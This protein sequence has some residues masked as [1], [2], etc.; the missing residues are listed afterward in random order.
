MTHYRVRKS[1]RK[2]M[3]IHILSDGQVE[4]RAPLRTPQA[5][6]DRF[7]MEKAQWIEAASTEARKRYKKRQEF[8]LKDGCSL[9]Y[10]GKRLPLVCC[11]LKKPLFDREC[12]YIPEGFTEEKMK[13]AVVKLYRSEA[14]KVLTEKVHYFA[15]HMHAKP[16]NVRINAARTRWGSCSGKNSL[17]FSWKLMMAP[18]RAVDYVVIHELAHTFEHNHSSAFWSIVTAFMPDYKMQQ[19]IL[20]ELGTLLST[21][22]WE[23]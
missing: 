6:L 15:E 17:N 9:F 14:K 22:D 13:E 5:I 1:R 3:A 12:F 7:V 4:V 20:K 8:T 21:Q 16:T 10:L 2:T 18:E 19:S 11:E 23:I